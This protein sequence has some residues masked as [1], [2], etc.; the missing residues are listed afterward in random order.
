MKGGSIK[1]SV[2]ELFWIKSHCTMLRR[3]A[4][5]EFVLKFGRSDVSL[6]NYHAL[7]KR[8]GWHTGRDGKF[9]SGQTSHNKGKSHPTTGRMGDT[10]FKKGGLP[11]NHR[12]PGHERICKKD[13]YV[14]LIVPEKNPWTGAATRPVHKHRWMWE[15]EN[16]QLPEKHALK[17]LDGDKTNCDPKNWMSIPRAILPRLNGRFGRDFDNAPAELKPPILATAM[18]EYKAREAKKERA[19]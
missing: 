3:A 2:E 15:R 5:T 19:A 8:K 17:C 18:L 13:G 6:D 12:G 11:H 10:Q 16:G 14:I 9:Q 7:C 4:H 1:Y